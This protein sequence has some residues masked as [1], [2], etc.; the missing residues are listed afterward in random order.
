MRTAALS[1][2]LANAPPD[3]LMVAMPDSRRLPQ[4]RSGRG[5]RDACRSR[6]FTLIELM[7]VVAIIAILASLAYPA[8]T[9]AILKGKRAQG[10]TAV[11]DL[12]QQQERYFTQNGSYMS[13]AVGASGN[14]GT[15]HVAQTGQ[16]IPFKTTSGD[17][18]SSAAYR[19]FAEPCPGAGS[20]NLA[21]NECIRIVADPGASSTDPQ[22]SIRATST[23]VKDCVKSGTASLCWK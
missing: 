7:I 13:F 16:N 6:G 3:R 9:G 14:N 2:S 4:L 21:L 1:I 11:L 20:T 22:G 18:P 15:I 5:A 10:R 12:L 19:L 23:G 8:Y 17:N